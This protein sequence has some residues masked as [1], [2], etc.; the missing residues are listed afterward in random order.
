MI[1]KYLTMILRDKSFFKCNDTKFN[2]KSITDDINKAR[3]K[4]SDG[5]KETAKEVI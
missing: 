3:K 1:I 5:K 4:S 2:I